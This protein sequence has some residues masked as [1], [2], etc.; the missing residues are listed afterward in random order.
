MDELQQLVEEQ[1]DQQ[2]KAAMPY[3]VAQI[4]QRQPYL[5]QGHKVT[6]RLYVVA[7]TAPGGQ[8]L[9]FLF[10]NGKVTALSFLRSCFF[11]ALDGI[12]AISIQPRLH[13]SSALSLPPT[14]SLSPSSSRFPSLSPSLS[15][16]CTLPLS[17][18][19]SPAANR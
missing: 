5:V 12:I 2:P 6:L 18:S 4:F 10:R 13:P 14:H 1:R 15:L 9:G 8:G 17:Y 19:L 16:S 11:H 7:V 3:T